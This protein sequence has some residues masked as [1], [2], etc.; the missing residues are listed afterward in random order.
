VTA[1]KLGRRFAGW[2]VLSDATDARGCVLCRCDCGAVSSLHLFNLTSGA[3]QCG[4]P[5]CEVRVVATSADRVAKSHLD[6]CRESADRRYARA[7]YAGRLVIG[8]VLPVLIVAAVLM[9][10]AD[11]LLGAN[12]RWA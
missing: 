11:A 1:L 8:A 2:T 6:A 7:T 9:D 10:L 3:A 4:G 5:G 12:R